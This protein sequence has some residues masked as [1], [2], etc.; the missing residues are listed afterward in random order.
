MRRILIVLACIS[1]L[2]VG[3]SENNLP[4]LFE[5]K[6]F[7]GI[8][9]LLEFYNSGTFKMEKRPVFLDVELHTEMFGRYSHSGDMVFLEYD[10][11]IFTDKDNNSKTLQSEPRID[12]LYKREDGC[13]IYL[14]TKENLKGY[15]KQKDRF[16]GVI[17]IFL[18]ANGCK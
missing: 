9:Y 7:S 13:I 14:L 6:D 3:C 12:T 5:S 15:E 18:N 10:S 2:A 16:K 8:R 1:L 17:E 11:I 4:P